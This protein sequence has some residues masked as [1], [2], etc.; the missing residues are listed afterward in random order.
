MAP[1]QIGGVV[2]VLRIPLAC[3]FGARLIFSGALPLGVTMAGCCAVGVGNCMAGYGG[4]GGGGRW[5][6]CNGCPPCCG[7]G[8]TGG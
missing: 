1:G 6:F 4:I 5:D 8:A 2:C 3:G 7:N